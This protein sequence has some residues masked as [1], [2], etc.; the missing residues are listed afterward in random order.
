MLVMIPATVGLLVLAEPIVRLAFVWKGGEFGSES[1]VL[2]ARAVCGYAPGLVAFSL[3]RVL[4]PVFYALQDTRT[5]VQVGVRVVGLNF[6]LNIA[7]ILTWPS[8]Y[9]HAGL[10]FATVLASVVNCV[11][12]GRILHRRVG[13]LG[14][15][16]IAKSMA[17]IFTASLVMGLVALMSHNL[18]AG[19][20][21]SA[22]L[23]PKFY[24]LVTV[25]GGITVGLAVYFVLAVVLCREEV[26]ELA[27]HMRN[28]AL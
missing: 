22:R 10:A 20:V 2:T 3:Y 26:K 17:R 14:W 12:L 27:S 24:Q 5:P 19:S 23:S 11:A 28:S 18:L 1:T 16:R 6:L 8:G 9:K 25:G 7:F 13:S 4:V 15:N 21:I